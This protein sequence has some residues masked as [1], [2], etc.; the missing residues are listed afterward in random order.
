MLYINAYMGN[1]KNMVLMNLVAGQQWRCRHRE[2]T[3]GHG[4]AEERGGGMN[5]ESVMGTHT[6]PHIK[7][8]ASGNWLYD[9]ELKLG[10]VTT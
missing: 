7:V 3:Y 10:S 2:Q 8:L 4:Q 6:S 1:L 5:R 9:S